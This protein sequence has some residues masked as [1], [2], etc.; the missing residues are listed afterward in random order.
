MSQTVRIAKTVV[1]A[2]ILLAV[3]AQTGWAQGLVEPPRGAGP[4]FRLEWLRPSWKNRGIFEFGA[5]TSVLYGS[6]DVPITRSMR[7]L[8]EIPFSHASVAIA[9][10]EQTNTVIGNPYLGLRLMTE[11]E[12]LDIEFGARLPVSESGRIAVISGAAADVGR[13]DAFAH[14][15]V[16]AGANVL[17][18]QP[19]ARGFT[20]RARV[21]PSVW[22][23]TDGLHDDPEVSLAYDG[24]ARYETA[25]VRAGIGMAGQ[26]RALAPEGLERNTS[27]IGLNT[28]FGSGRIRP[29]VHLHVPVG[30]LA[31][32]VNMVAGVSVQISMP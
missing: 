19:L 30:V 17:I 21:G 13:L 4:V 14:S 32:A 28:D 23:P 29:G 12:Q 27:Q 11:N 24:Q 6:A 3:A 26:F 18:R 16:V 25:R 2:A 9:G 22:I 31:D 20:L 1:G 5:A 10:F 8:L 15:T 7:A